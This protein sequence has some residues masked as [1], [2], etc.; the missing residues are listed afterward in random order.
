MKYE[1]AKRLKRG[2]IVE[3][4]GT[5]VGGNPIEPEGNYLVQYVRETAAGVLVT[6]DNGRS[7]MHKHLKHPPTIQS[8]EPFYCSWC[9]GYVTDI[10]RTNLTRE[11]LL[12]AK[13][14]LPEPKPK[15]RVG[16]PVI[17]RGL[18]YRINSVQKYPGGNEFAYTIKDA[19]MGVL[20]TLARESLL[21][22]L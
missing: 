7:V 5:D 3:I 22:K 4:R 8:D 20:R 9:R 15:F 6:L 10:T 2:D 1:E 17:Y 16:D 14:S 11:Q 13:V 21:R 12:R 18:P 19:Q